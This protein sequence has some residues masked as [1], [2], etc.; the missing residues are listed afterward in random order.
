MHDR[1]SAGGAD[2]LSKIETLT[3]ADK[4]IDLAQMDRLSEYFI[5]YYGRPGASSG[6][7][8]WLENLAGSLQGNESQ[9]V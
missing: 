8:Y 5:A 4:L 1:P 3:F 2:T 6:I 7:D 9:L